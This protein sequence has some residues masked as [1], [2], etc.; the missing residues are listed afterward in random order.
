MTEN[1][2][3]QKNYLILFKQDLQENTFLKNEQ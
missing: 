1:S 3:A 2:K